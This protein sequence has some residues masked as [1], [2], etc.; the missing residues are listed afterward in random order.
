MWLQC[1]LLE[2]G[3][4]HIGAQRRAVDQARANAC[5]HVRLRVANR[6]VEGARQLLQGLG[7]VRRV[8]ITREQHGELV[9]ADARQQVGASQSHAQS[10]A[11]ADEDGVAAGASVRLVEGAE[12]VDVE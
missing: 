11:E 9:G 1:Q 3:K 8:P 7:H 4:H 5:R 6:N 12:V 10:V 2:L